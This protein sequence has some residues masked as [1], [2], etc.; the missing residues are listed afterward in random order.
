MQSL[1]I[2]TVPAQSMS[3]AGQVDLLPL[4]AAG[5]NT[6]FLFY[7]PYIPV[8]KITTFA[9]K[10]PKYK[11]FTDEWHLI[12]TWNEVFDTFIEVLKLAYTH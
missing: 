1:K 5:K 9:Y 4:G 10:I 3:R 7:H 6:T 12:S 2:F 8:V 11:W